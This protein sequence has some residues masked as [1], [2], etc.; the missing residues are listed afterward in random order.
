MSKRTFG[1]CAES[2]IREY[3]GIWN[4]QTYEVNVRALRRVSDTVSVLHSHGDITHLDPR[5]M[6]VYDVK[7]FVI[8]LKEDRR[9][10]P[11][12]VE[13]ELSFF[14]KVCMSCGNDCVRFARA[15][16]PYLVPK[17][18]KGGRSVL[19]KDQVGVILD[20]VFS[21]GVQDRSSYMPVI[22]ALATGARTNEFRHMRTEDVDLTVPCV[23]IMVPKGVA[24]YGRRR[25]VPVR[26]EFIGILREW[27]DLVGEGYLLP[28]PFTG[29]ILSVNALEVHRRSL[30]REIGFFFD[31]RQCRSTYGQM[32]KDE[33]FP[34]DTVSVI[35]GHSSTSVT[36]TFYARVRNTSA[37][38]D[39]VRRWYPSKDPADP[40][41]G[42]SADHK[43]SEEVSQQ[44]EN[45]G[46]QG[47]IRTLG[48]QL[49]RLPPYPS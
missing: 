15:K 27:M 14:Q 12:S 35:L 4:G 47:G 48:L 23:R 10:S 40:A 24:S 41:S 30:C 37:I 39:I 5:D 22:V 31:Y 36:E 8:H 11:S 13:K 19:S 9:L 32:L 29:G 26:P 43:G 42:E 16:W 17:A 49:R 6:D 7:A 46:E 2:V 3:T 44:S 28:N 21:L 25:T 34:L 38:E 45:I 20:H 1:Q 33:G 18:S